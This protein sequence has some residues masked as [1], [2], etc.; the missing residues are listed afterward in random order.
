MASSE[1]HYQVFWEGNC[2]RLQASVN[3][4]SQW[5]Q[6]KGPGVFWEKTE[7][8][9]LH[10]RYI[11]LRISSEHGSWMFTNGT[12]LTGYLK[13]IFTL[14][15]KQSTLLWV[16]WGLNWQSTGCTWLKSTHT[17]TSAVNG[18]IISLFIF[19]HLW[20]I[21]WHSTAM[22]LF[23]HPKE[24]VKKLLLHS[25]A[26]P[27]SV[28]VSGAQYW[29]VQLRTLWR[30]QSI[31]SRTA[32]MKATR[33]LVMPFC[34]SRL[35]LWDCDERSGSYYI[36]VSTDQQHWTEVC[37]CQTSSTRQHTLTLRFT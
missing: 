12:L 17:F 4:P 13:R 31:T 2:R 14:S 20:P 25:A 29:S 22:F 32:A 26:K 5:K 16:Y 35:L 10:T 11:Y 34:C 28:N 24:Q 7:E 33:T 18:R 1:K 6:L 36:E 27:I 23:H 21:V 19:F 30:F 15:E 3:V 9:T 37:V 8:W